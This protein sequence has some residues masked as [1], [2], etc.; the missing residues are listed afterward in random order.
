MA[1]EIQETP[2]WLRQTEEGLP[3]YQAPENAPVGDITPGELTPEVAA[4]QA[5]EAAATRVRRSVTE[6][7]PIESEPMARFGEAFTE[8]IT[9]GPQEAIKSWY[10]TTEGRYY[11]PNA[12]FVTEEGTFLDENQQPIPD[13]RK[14][15]VAP[16]AKDPTTGELQP[17]M[18][19]IL[20]IWQT[21]GSPAGTLGAGPV[22]RRAP[23][24]GHNQGPPI[25]TTPPLG[26]PPAPP[27]HTGPPGGM[28]PPPTGGAPAALAPSP[29]QIVHGH[30]PSEKTTLDGLYTQVFDNLHPLKVLQDEVAE[31]GALRP[32]EHFYELARL[33]RGAH[34]RTRQM[35]DNATFDYRT[36]RNN[37]MPLRDVL[38]PVSK[39]LDEFENFAVAMRDLELIQRGINPG[40]TAAE[41]QNII[42]AAPG[43]FLPALKNLHEYQYRTLKYLKDSGIISDEQMRAMRA[44]N[45]MYVPF[46]RVMDSNE[47]SAGGRYLRVNNPIRRVKGSDR[48][49]LS[50]IES[51]IRNTHKFIDLAEKNR[52]LNALVDAAEAR[53]LTDL[54]ERV[55][56]TV[57]PINVLTKEMEKF[58]RDHGIPIHPALASAPDHF[59]IFRPNAFRPEPG[60]ISVW[61]N[62]KRHVYRVDPDVAD[63]VNGMN[64]EMIG[65]I[66]EWASWP[67]RALRAGVVMAPEFL[68]K[69]LFRDQIM[70]A[71]QSPYG[72]VPVFDYIRGLGHMIG[73][74]DTYQMWLKSGGANVSMTNMDRKYLNEEIRAMME[75]GWMDALRAT[76]R[77]PVRTTLEVAE[78]FQSLSEHPTRVG[79]FA[80]GRKKGETPHL[81]GYSSREATT[82]FGRRGSNEWLNTSMRMSS[83][84]RP[85]IQGLDRL[86]RQFKEKPGST[87]FKVAAYV[88]VPTLGFYF[89]NRQDPRVWDIPRED[90]ALFWHKM[91]DNW[92]PIS[93]EDAKRIPARYHKKEDGQDYVNLGVPARF[94]KPF[95]TGFY[96]GTT[97]EMALDAFFTE[98]PEIFKELTGA[99]FTPQPDPFKRWGKGALS[100]T[101]PGVI[102]QYLLPAI[103]GT[104]NYSFFRERP[105]VPQYRRSPENRKYEYT[106]FTSLTAKYVGALISKMVPESQLASPI[107]IDNYIR[108]LSG[109]LG[110]YGTQL[111]DQTL[112]AG[113]M[114]AG[115]EFPEP[116]AWTVADYPVIKAFVSRLPST[117]ATPITDF[118]ENLDNARTTKALVN[119][120]AKSPSM[121]PEEKKA[122]RTAI[123]QD[124]AAVTMASTAKAMGV[125]MRRIESVQASKTIKP[126]E[127]TRLI[128]LLSLNMMQ[129]ADH[130]NRQYNQLA[131]KREKKKQG[132]P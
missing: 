29:R 110:V 75:S 57:H 66:A 43:H 42:N 20:D 102:P 68:A 86:A 109:T 89:Y 74:T 56:P 91:N 116:P 19:G 126:E 132:Q 65:K 113:A 124:R 45:R 127:K 1:D 14:P 38:A 90:R 121:D 59:T 12:K 62:G 18:P 4:E 24:I 55:K 22:L 101:L 122:E 114:V 107:V 61:K 25:G 9:K 26:P 31:S 93:P 76:V 131:G 51:I 128:Q 52:A 72:Y 105:L 58:L 77:H 129:I 73:K 108:G 115:K 94:P 103:E 67:A 100:A 112:K 5:R 35:L 39:E 13:Q 40:T 120:I 87:A 92:Q 28:P 15:D 37:G 30:D 23:G 98:H 125:L 47:G 50:P 84:A 53:G 46:Y 54:V 6:R 64:A 71:I 106:P 80:K 78:G 21:T 60:Q 69:N 123:L 117:I 63:A 83:F 41:A 79:V 81:S 33:T 17:A 3:F 44:A 130:A 11:P 10:E 70:A 97:L 32:E 82:D 95:E 48:D 27:P 8:G 85:T 2:S 34:G 96:F 16:I 49:I 111:L 119:R 118:Y 104:S 88:G 7:L 99:D 36:L